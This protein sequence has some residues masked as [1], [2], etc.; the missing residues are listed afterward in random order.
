MKNSFKK[1]LRNYFGFSH[2]EMNGFLVVIFL[3]VSGIVGRIAYHYYWVR[4]P[5]PAVFSKEEQAKT[6]QWLTEDQNQPEQPDHESK[7]KPHQSAWSYQKFDPNQASVAQMQ[8]MMPEWLAK[9]IVKYREKVR[10]FQH[11]EQLKNIYGL[12]GATFDR[13]SPYIQ[14]DP[15]YL[16]ALNKAK[17]EDLQNED[18]P[19]PAKKYLKKE[20]YVPKWKNLSVNVNT[21]DSINLQV[22]PGIGPGFAH[23]IIRYRKMLGGF[24]KKAQLSEVYGLPDSTVNLLRQHTFITETPHLHKIPVNTDSVK[25]LAQHPYISW[26]LAR[27]MVHYRQQHG[28]YDSP[29]DLLALVLVDS[30]TLRQLKPYLDFSERQ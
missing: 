20:E 11:K 16:A 9:R 23:R 15:K 2:R 27:L 5:L 8:K 18:Q 13:L 28:R 4:Q 12:N 26:N 21:I 10:P 22:F 1:W 19:K 7:Y 14:L 3:M 29:A 25:V 6:T 24:V 30:T 17:E